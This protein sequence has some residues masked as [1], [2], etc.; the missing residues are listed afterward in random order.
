MGSS[1]KLHA[2]IHFVFRVLVL[3]RL[4]GQGLSAF[5]I[6]V[7]LRI[8]FLG[9]VTNIFNRTIVDVVSIPH[10]DEYNSAS[11]SLVAKGF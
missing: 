7:I 1:L 9:T 4:H 5:V 11:D 10:E 3:S 6:N 8:L 2:E